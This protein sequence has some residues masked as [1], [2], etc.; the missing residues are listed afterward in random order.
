LLAQIAGTTEKITTKTKRLKAL[1]DETDTARRLQ[2]M[3]GVGPLT[4]LAVEAFEGTDGCF[5]RGGRLAGKA[6][7]AVAVKVAKEGHDMRFDIP[8]VGPKTIEVCSANG[9]GVLAIEAGRTLLLDQPELE[10]LAVARKVAV[11]AVH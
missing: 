9:I 4:A 10:A 7:G 3:P 8:C 11:L 6:G 5:E 2:T 1:A